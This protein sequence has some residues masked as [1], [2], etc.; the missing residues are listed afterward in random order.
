M[1]IPN[2]PKALK[3]CLFVPLMII[4]IIMIGKENIHKTKTDLSPERSAALRIKLF[5]QT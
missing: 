2:F 4:M 5:L 1:N 3:G